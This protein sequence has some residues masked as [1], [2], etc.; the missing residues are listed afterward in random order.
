MTN[1]LGRYLAVAVDVNAKRKEGDIGVLKP[2]F[3]DGVCGYL[4]DAGEHAIRIKE[5]RPDLRV[6]VVE[7]KAEI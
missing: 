1:K 3:A 6:Y 2:V 7:V 5:K 4:D